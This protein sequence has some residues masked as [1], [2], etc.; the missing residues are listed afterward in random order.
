VALDDAIH[1]TDPDTLLAAAS[2]PALT[3]DLA[4]A[5]LKRTDLSADAVERLAKNGTVIKAR[6]VKIALACHPHTPRH[7]SLPMIRGLYTFDLMNVA[8]A[9]VTPAD[10]KRVADEALIVRVPTISSGERL[11]LARRASAGVAAALLTDKESRVMKTALENP[12]LTEA[13]I[14]KAVNTRSA[15]EALV[16]A[17]CH[18]PKWSLRHEVQIALLRNEKTPLAQALRYAQ[19][20]SA[21]QLREVLRRSRLPAGTK[22]YLLEERSAR[23]AR[24]PNKS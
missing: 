12:R 9:P 11:T 2:D 23:K 24:L 15:P 16:Q 20:L 4:L 6:K 8:L 13:A 3:E 14:V 21:A 17:V 1:S 5:L 19:R 7:V 10:V 22:A 18:H